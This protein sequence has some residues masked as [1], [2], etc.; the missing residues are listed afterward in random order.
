MLAIYDDIG[1]RLQPILTR[2][3]YR[4]RGEI[5]MTLLPGGR[6]HFAASMRSV[7]ADFYIMRSAHIEMAA[8][9]EASHDAGDEAVG[10]RRLFGQA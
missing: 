10:E 4:H 9:R 1:L 6:R 3:D 5:E 8:Y 2:V 7:S